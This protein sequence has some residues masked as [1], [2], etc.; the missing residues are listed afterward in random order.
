M[1]LLWVLWYV[2][3][4]FIWAI[5]YKAPSIVLLKIVFQSLQMHVEVYFVP[6]MNCSMVQSAVF[7]TGHI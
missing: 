6:F 3:I 5:V 2:N 1:V 7:I 4:I